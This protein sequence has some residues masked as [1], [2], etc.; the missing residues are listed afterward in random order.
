VL[1]RSIPS[2]SSLAG[3]ATVAR[4][5]PNGSYEV[6]LTINGSAQYGSDGLPS[7][8]NWS[9]Q[10]P[11]DLITLQ[12]AGGSATASV[13]LGDDGSIDRSWTWTTTTLVD[14]AP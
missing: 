10:L 4:S 3:S 5:W 9:L 11:D 14:G 2:S 1:F 6:T 12:L 13:D 7:S 8:G